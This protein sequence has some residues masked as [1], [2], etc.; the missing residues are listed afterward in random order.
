M[1]NRK[2]TKPVEPARASAADVARIQGGGLVQVIV[3]NTNPLTFH[4]FLNDRYLSQNEIESIVVT[5]EA[6]GAGP[7]APQVHAGLARYERTAGGGRHTVQQELFPCC[8]ELV[9]RGRRLL[10]ICT[11]AGMFDGLW[12][13][14]GMRPDGTSSQIS[15]AMAL[16]VVIGD[17]LFDGRITWSDGTTDNLFPSS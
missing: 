8:F 5:I 16:R 12:I 10:I 1:F 2:P 7:S 11:Q 4:T 17:G 9:A 13:E 3:T 6:P 15:G 14:L